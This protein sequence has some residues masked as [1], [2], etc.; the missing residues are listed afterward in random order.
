MQ[1][2]AVE[3]EQGVDLRD[4]AVH[5]PGGAHFSPVDDKFANDS[6]DIYFDRSLNPYRGCEHGCIYC[7][8]R[9]THS[10]LNL[11]PGLDF[12]TKLIAKRNIGR[13]AAAELARKALP[14]EHD[15]HRH[16]HRLLPAGRARAAAHA[17]G[18]RGAA[19]VPT[20]RSRWSPSQ[21]GRARHRPDR[22]DGGSGPGR[23]VRHHHHARR[24][25]GPQA[26]AARRRAAPAAAHHPHAGRGRHSLWA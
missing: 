13:G 21:R 16:R 7:Y 18:A 26:G 22:A 1:G 8:A 11:S 9:P 24:R 25:A 20:I 5:A 4:G 23:G 6:P 12:E 17:L 19:R 15:R 3:E 14:A 10:Y 2:A